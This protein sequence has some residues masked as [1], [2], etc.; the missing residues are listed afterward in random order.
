M[1]LDQP[2]LSER[3]GRYRL[4]VSFS[5]LHRPLLPRLPTLLAPGGVILLETFH[6]GYLEIRKSFRREW[7]LDRGE[8]ER[9]FPELETLATGHDET[10]AFVLATRPDQ[11]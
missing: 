3:A 10:R 9:L 7:V 4:V 5:F 2:A 11:D 6:E 1:D 8:E